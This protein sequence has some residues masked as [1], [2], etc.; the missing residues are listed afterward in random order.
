[1]SQLQ[2]LTFQA[3]RTTIIA[4]NLPSLTRLLQFCDYNHC[5]WELNE[6]LKTSANFGPQ[7]KQI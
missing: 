3:L 4:Y 5:Y 6:C 2:N 1:M 7:I